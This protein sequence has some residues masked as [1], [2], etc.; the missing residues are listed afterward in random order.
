MIFFVFKNEYFKCTVCEYLSIFLLIY[1]MLIFDFLQMSDFPEKPPKMLKK[2]S[3]VYDFASEFPE[4][5]AR[6]LRFFAEG[7]VVP[8][9]KLRLM[10]YDGHRSTNVPKENLESTP[11]RSAENL[12]D[13][14][15]S[16][17][18]NEQFQKSE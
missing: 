15:I 7:N 1:K 10:I 18:N 11:C 9:K 8:E 5:L 3:A 17:E 16:V 14:G 13:D 6:C 2:R 4:Q 12:E